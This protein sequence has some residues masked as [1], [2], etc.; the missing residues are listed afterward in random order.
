MSYL[1]AQGAGG[2]FQRRLRTSKRIFFFENSVNLPLRQL[3]RR[4]TMRQLHANCGVEWAVSRVSTTDTAFALREPGYEI[5]MASVSITPAVKAEVVRWVQATRDNLQ[6]FAHGVCVNQLGD[7][8]D[9]L[10]GP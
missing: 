5:D 4:S 8:S 2:F 3:Q 10:V 6:P 9:Q 7:T 1:E